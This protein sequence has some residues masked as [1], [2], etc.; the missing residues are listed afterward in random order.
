[1]VLTTLAG[2]RASTPGGPSHDEDALMVPPADEQPGPAS[3]EL[4]LYQLTELKRARA[5][6]RRSIHDE[7]VALKTEMRTRFDSLAFVRKDTFDDYKASSAERDRETRE[8]ANS[9]RTL[10]QASLWVLIVAVVAGIVGL[11]FQVAA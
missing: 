1:M 9:A 11:A 8:I 3:L 5:D 10:A 4:V 7:L 6:D 2:P